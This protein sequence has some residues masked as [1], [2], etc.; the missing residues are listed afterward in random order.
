MKKDLMKENIGSKAFTKLFSSVGLK[1]MVTQPT[2]ITVNSESCIDHVLT[3]DHSIIT[4][5]FKTDISDLFGVLQETNFFAETKT[6]KKEALTSRNFHKD[7]KNDNYCC[8][9]LFNLLHEL[10]TFDY[11]E[12]NLNEL[13]DLIIPKSIDKTMFFMQWMQANFIV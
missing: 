2:K 11:S 3:K 5:V 4:R 8:K 1:Q 6:V 7:L 12:K 13:I 9:F 10:K